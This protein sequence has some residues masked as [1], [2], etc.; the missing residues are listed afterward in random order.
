MTRKSKKERIFSALEVANICGVVNQTAINWIKNDYLKAFTTPGGQYRVY[1]EDLMEFL[2]S[3]G[4]KI[5]DELRELL[6]GSEFKKSILIVDD[7]TQFNNMLTDYLSKK[8]E[9]MDILQAF[10]GFQAGRI[11]SE[12]KPRVI[13]LD[14]DLPGVDGHKLCKT[15]KGDENLEN[16]CVIAVTGLDDTRVEAA[17]LKAGADKFFPKPFEFEEILECITEQAANK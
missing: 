15:I 6:N 17:L 4:M 11:I 9:D 3:R 14:V 10:D 8:L 12:R 5:P 1:A 2:R 13:I 16:P 7:D